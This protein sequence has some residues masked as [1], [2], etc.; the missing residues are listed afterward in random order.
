VLP[1][2]LEV[3][4]AF[5]LLV[6]VIGLI[7]WAR[8]ARLVRGVVMSARTRDYVVAARSLGASEFRVL[9][10][11]VIPQTTGVVVT[12]AALLVPQYILAEVTLPFLG[13]GVGEPAPSWGTMLAGAHPLEATVRGKR[14]PRGGSAAL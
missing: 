10:R 1:L 12:Q 3:R 2:H 7:G 5:L 9:I 8:P 6:V 4:D 11:H 13:L 14:N